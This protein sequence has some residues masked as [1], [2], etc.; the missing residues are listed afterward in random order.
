MTPLEIRD[1]VVSRIADNYDRTPISWPNR[2]FDP[3]VE[4]PLGH[5]IRPTIIFGTTEMSEL[6]TDGVGFR[7]GVLKIQVF[8]PKGKES[9]ETWTN[10]GSLEGLFRREVI[11]G[12]IFD[13]PSTNEIG[14]SE[15][16][17]QL[18]VDVPFMAFVGE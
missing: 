7:Y 11:D 3:D 16:F 5:W 12:I 13:E 8:G 14:N 18:A 2:T 17:Y 4:A 9:R 10:A 1:E 6:G 15:K